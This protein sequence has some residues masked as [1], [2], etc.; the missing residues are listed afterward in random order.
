MY[1]VIFRSRGYNNHNIE[2]IVPLRE[3]GTFNFSEIKDEYGFRAP[4]LHIKCWEDLLKFLY[5][6]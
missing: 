1:T 4:Y 6:N 2:L 5:E 3:D